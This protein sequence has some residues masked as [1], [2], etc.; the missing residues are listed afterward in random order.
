MLL[1]N[2]GI[3]TRKSTKSRVKPIRKV[4]H[5][6]KFIKDD[7]W[8]LHR[9]RGGH[10]H[11]KHPSKAGIV[12]VPKQLNADIRLGTLNSALKQAGLKK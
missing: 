6:I 2:K 8:N 9:V 11:F 3:Q 4:K 5:L 1:D 7:G 10:K 12:T